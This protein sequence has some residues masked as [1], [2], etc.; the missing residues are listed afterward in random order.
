[1]F[2]D[3]D[4]DTV[5]FEAAN[6]SFQLHYQVTPAE[7][8]AAYN[9]AQLVT[10][11]L[12]SVA[13]N[14]ST[15]FGR[16]LWRETRVALFGHVA[17]SRSRTHCA[18]GNPGRV[19]FGDR[20][21]DHSVVELFRD[22]VARFR[23]LLYR[24]KDENPLQLLQQGQIPELSTLCLHNGTVWRWNRPCYGLNG[25]VP[26]LRIE[27]RVLPSGPTVL[28]EVA[29]S[30]FFSGL[31]RALPRTMTRIKEEVPFEEA[32]NNFVAASRE[33]LRAKFFWFGRRVA[34]DELIAEELLPA[35]KEGLRM[36]RVEEKDI[37]RYLDVIDE[38]LRNGQ[39][40]AQWYLMGRQKANDTK[41]IRG[42]A[43]RALTAA[44]LQRQ[45]EGE[46]VHRWS[47]ASQEELFHQAQKVDARSLC[48]DEMMST[49]LITLRRHDPISIA[50]SMMK[51]RKMRHIPV[52][53]DEGVVVGILN[54]AELEKIESS[55]SDKL[56]QEIMQ[57][58]ICVSPNAPFLEIQR[59][60]DGAPGRCVLVVRDQ[61]LI[62]II[63]DR[64]L[65]HVHLIRNEDS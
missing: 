64:D 14:S 9:V 16:R 61:R 39:T 12:I 54:K 2:L 25:Q 26:H 33:G 44:Y 51:W 65:P 38:R 50:C 11:P 4:A 7:F 45:T 28:D 27:N 29:N 1:M 3:V 22:N 43:D 47:P 62:G 5:M 55:E 31:M 19:S 57:D 20:W 42:F 24:A 48:A 52:E 49:D 17:D 34:A 36:A 53:S 18:R 15:L 10:A 56:V 40:G 8:A 37:K 35:A 58:A 60:L 59:K 6:T 46:P 30:A 63:T 32:R 41:D 13:A 21:I 23:S